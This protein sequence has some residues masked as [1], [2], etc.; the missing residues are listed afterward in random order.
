MVGAFPRIFGKKTFAF[1]GKLFNSAAIGMA[2]PISLYD[3]K[4]G[5]SLKTRVWWSN[6]K[7]EIQCWDWEFNSLN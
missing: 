1:Q 7:I 3:K 5:Y 2:D 6:E 4:Q